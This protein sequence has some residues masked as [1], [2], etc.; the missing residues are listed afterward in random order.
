MRRLNVPRFF[1]FHLRLHLA[2]TSI[3]SFR[4]PRFS[5]SSF[6]KPSPTSRDRHFIFFT[7]LSTLRP[8]LLHPALLFSFSI[9][10]PYR[11]PLD[12]SPSQPPS[13][14]GPS[15]LVIF[16]PT[17]FHYLFAPVHIPILVPTLSLSLLLSSSLFHFSTFITLHSPTFPSLFIVRARPLI[18]PL[19]RAL[20]GNSLLFFARFATRAVARATDKFCRDIAFGI[21]AIMSAKYLPCRPSPPVSSVYLPVYIYIY[22]YISAT[23]TYIYIY[24]LSSTLLELG[25]WEARACIHVGPNLHRAFNIGRLRHNFPAGGQSWP[26]GTRGSLRFIPCTDTRISGEICTKNAA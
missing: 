8:T 2:S 5:S 11:G 12:S 18:I 26:S 1:S 24:T 9:L 10:S 4:L 6:F 21:I 7:S 14:P 25:V 13:T 17:L 20:S 22:K 3:P 19:F 15:T 23:H 16:I